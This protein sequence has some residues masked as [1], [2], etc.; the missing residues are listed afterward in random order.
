MCLWSVVQS[1]KYAVLSKN[2]PHFLPF[3]LSIFNRKQNSEASPLPL[4][5]AK[6][7]ALWGVGCLSL[8]ARTAGLATILRY[9]PIL[10]RGSPPTFLLGWWWRGEVQ[11]EYRPW[12]LKL[13]D[14]VR[15][16]VFTQGHGGA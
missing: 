16:R 10:I 9:Q 1:Y 12:L 11:G 13:P 15:E 4:L 3:P 6:S 2:L 7:T 14:L 8:N 5:A